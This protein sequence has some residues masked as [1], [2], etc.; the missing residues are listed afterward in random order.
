VS[1]S[2]AFAPGFALA[3]LLLVLAGAGCSGGDDDGD[4]DGDAPQDAGGGGTDAVPVLN[5]CA[6]DDYADFSA[7]GDER[8]VAI[9]QTGLTFTPKCMIVAVGQS[10]RWDGN[11]SAHPL[12]PGN[13]DD[14]L[15][16]SAENPI[17]ATSSGSEVEFT[18]D[19]PGVYP[20]YCTLHAFGAGQGMAGVVRAR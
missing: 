1:C 13:P 14:A 2:R 3:S 10:V 4:D 18:F 17:T 19:A 6:A 7:G 9:A 12:A 11:L 16:G 20:Y 15:A 5:G 8:V